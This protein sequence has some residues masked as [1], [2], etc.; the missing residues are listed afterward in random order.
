[1]KQ[2]LEVE[3]GSFTLFTVSHGECHHCLLQGVCLS[4]LPN[5]TSPLATPLLDVAY[6]MVGNFLQEVYYYFFC[7]S[8]VIRKY[9]TAKFSLPMSTCTTSNYLAIL[10]PREEP[11]SECA[12]ESH[13]SDLL[14]CYVKHR[15]MNQMVARSREWKQSPLRMGRV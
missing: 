9:K 15:G 7:Q 11:V 1:M 6:R 14:G 8:R 3:H 12:L 10:T 13:W 4:T 2:S 5:E